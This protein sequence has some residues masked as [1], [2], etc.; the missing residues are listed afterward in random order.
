MKYTAYFMTNGSQ[1]EFAVG[2]GGESIYYRLMSIFGTYD[3]TSSTFQIIRPLNMTDTIRKSIFDF[4]DEHSTAH[5]QLKGLRSAFE[6][7][8]VG[9]FFI[10]LGSKPETTEEIILNESILSVA[11]KYGYV[12]DVLLDTELKFFNNPDSR[13]LI[14]NYKINIL[15]GRGR[16]SIGNVRQKDRRCRFCGRSKI[17]GATFKKNAHAMPEGIGTL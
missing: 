9:E 5:P 10:L 16:V 7:I 13:F 6:K 3:E 14:N 2:Q 4:C 1:F 11:K 8:S 15:S 12:D 17:D